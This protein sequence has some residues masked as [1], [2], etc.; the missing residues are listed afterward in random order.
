MCMSLILRKTSRWWYGYYRIDGKERV[1]PL[2]VQ[3]EGQRPASLSEEGDSSFEQ[4]RGRALAEHDR[5]K[6]E[7]LEKRNLAQLTQKLIE[8]KTGEDNPVKS[9]PL[10]DLSSRWTETREKPKG[11]TKYAG[12]VKRFSPGSSSSWGNSIPRRRNCC[13]LGPR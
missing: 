5:V 4:S 9:V 13:W 1:V 6:K 3:V 11:D 10:A 12:E 7:I 2:G 8:I